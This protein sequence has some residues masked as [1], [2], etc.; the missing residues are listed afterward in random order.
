MQWQAR[1]LF[2]ESARNK[3]RTLRPGT[4]KGDEDRGWTSGNGDEL[5]EELRN[6]LWQVQATAGEDFAGLGLLVCNTPEALPIVPLRPESN[7][8]PG[9][10]LVDSLVAIS[11]PDSEYHD[12]FHIV[13]TGWRL[14]LLSQYFSPPIVEDAVIDRTKVFGGR[15]MAALF[16]SAIPGVE[17]S[18]IASGG[19]GVAIFRDGAERYFEA[20]P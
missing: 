19:F 6:L 5:I 1:L 16:G 18:G 11:S 12:G 14:S 20:A 9:R 2:R 17:L 8:A 10:K 4:G 13:S 7:P 3:A 15:Y